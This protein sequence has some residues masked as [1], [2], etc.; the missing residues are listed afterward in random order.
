LYRWGAAQGWGRAGSCTEEHG[1]LACGEWR[2]SWGFPS[3]QEPPQWVTRSYGAAPPSAAAAALAAAGDSEGGARPREWHTLV[4][5]LDAKQ[6][7]ALWTPAAP[8]PCRGVVLICPGSGTGAGPAGGFG[9]FCLFSRLAEALPEAGVGV[10]RLVPPAW[11][12][13]RLSV[14]VNAVRACVELIE[15]LAGPTDLVLLG[16]S[17]G[18]AAVIEAAARLLAAPPRV[19]LKG[20]V[21]LASQS[22]GLFKMGNRHG[23]VNSLQLALRVLGAAGVPLCC[24]HGSED[25][26]VHPSSTDK[27]ADQWAAECFA[28]G[29]VRKVVL[30]GDAHGVASALARGEIIISTML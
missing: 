3:S 23:R 9:P 19:A 21:T 2:S 14:S 29:L 7:H 26:C 20:V 25:V 27:I 17:M 15:G 1:P 13:G 5:P 10:L 6:L 12:Q 11:A 22:A 30:A 8:G 16:W 24:L 18:G 28:G 4:S